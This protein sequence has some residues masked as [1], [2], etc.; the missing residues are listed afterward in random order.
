[1]TTEAYSKNKT[2]SYSIEDWQGANKAFKQEL[3]YAIEDIEGEI[4]YDLTGT[5]YR[6]VPA[7]LDV[8]GERVHHPFDADG[9][10]CA[11]SFDRGKAHFRNRY[12]KTEGYLAEQKAD[13]ILY[14]G[15][16]GTE[17]SGGW[18][19]NAFDFKL[20]N[21]ANTNIVYW[22]GKLLALWEASHPHR[23]DPHTLETLGIATLNG[24]I[25]KGTPFSAHPMVDP[26][27]GVREPR[28]VNFGLKVGLSTTVSIYELN[29]AGEVIE[30]H[31]H[32]IPGFT[33]IHDF[34]ITPNYCLLFQNPLLFNPIP[35]ALGLRGA[36]ECIKFLS[37]K[38]TKI[39][40]IPRDSA[41]PMQ[42]LEIESGFIFHHANA[43]EREDEIV[44]DSV[45]YQ[46]FPALDHELDY[47]NIRFETVP[48]GQLWRYR[49]NLQTKETSRRL[50]D[51]RTVDFPYIHPNLIG[52]QHRWIY[53]GA[54]H[55]PE[56]NA[57]LQAVLKIDPESGEQQMWSAAPRGFVGEPVFVPRKDATSEDDGWVLVVVY[58]ASS[59]RSDVVILDAKNLNSEPLARLHLKHHLPYG[60]HGSFTSEVLIDRAKR[61]I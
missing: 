9:N 30:H 54:V 39:W 33:F 23:L 41:K 46:D 7:M 31:Q 43:F 48:P 6:N 47:N 50:I 3:D 15:V 42:Q 49:L 44:V 34:A 59:D 20:K 56:G 12:V 40:L 13:K 36:A 37:D 14:R 19:S 38:P 53:I 17:K 57:P 18:L 35:F 27:D 8:G 29:L 24:A 58:N 51:E 25:S 1:M 55:E 26:G 21:V 4:P 45:S 11:I 16:F 28:L 61:E 32:S 60:L 2:G 5:L 52:Q 22:G 10:I